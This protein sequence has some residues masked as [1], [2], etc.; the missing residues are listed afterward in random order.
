MGGGTAQSVAC[1][2]AGAAESVASRPKRTF[3]ECHRT[4]EGRQVIGFRVGASG[5][6]GDGLFYLLSVLACL[7]SAWSRSHNTEGEELVP[8]L[9]VAVLAA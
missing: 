5:D 6:A 4:G 9:A 3:V 7:F 8:Y 2:N 1:Y